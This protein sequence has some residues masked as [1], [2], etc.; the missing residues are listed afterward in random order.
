MITHPPGISNDGGWR[1]FRVNFLLDI[2]ITHV[3]LRVEALI[4]ESAADHMWFGMAAADLVHESLEDQIPREGMIIS[5]RPNAPKPPTVI[6]KTFN[7]LTLGWVAPPAYK[8]EDANEVITAYTLFRRL[9]GADNQPNT[10][11]YKEV[12]KLGNV[13][14]HTV[15][16]L[17]FGTRYQFLL[18]ATNVVGHSNYS[19][20]LLAE[21][22]PT[23]PAAPG[24]PG[25][26]GNASAH[27]MWIQYAKPSHTGAAPLTG[28]KVYK[29][30]VVVGPAGS[31]DSGTMYDTSRTAYFTGLLR[32]Q[33][34]Q[35]QVS[36][37]NAIGEG[38]KS[39]VSGLI[40][41]MLEKEC[42]VSVRI[43]R[44][45]KVNNFPY[46]IGK[47]QAF[48]DMFALDVHHA[49]DILPSRVE[50]T[51]T[52]PSTR[53]LNFQ[54]KTSGASGQKSVAEAKA[55]FI[56]SLVNKESKL[57]SGAVTYMLDTHY[58]FY[59]SIAPDLAA[60]RSSL[61]G[62]T[63]RLDVNVALLAGFLTFMVAPFLVCLQ[64]LIA[65]RLEAAEA[66]VAYKQKY[67]NEVVAG[68]GD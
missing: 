41:T 53:V 48:K 67:R 17:T 28:Y 13:N 3:E 8:E 2:H 12:A 55:D 58:L 54:L 26:Y 30:Q 59:D 66:A 15:T 50:V 63:Q 56:Q 11:E 42:N 43:R 40:E 20:P 29:R 57:H 6:A 61:G 1:E 46:G 64:G 19:E 33:S 45:E 10:L 32:G 4:D 44:D 7:S 18:R 52:N 36:A 14:S 34:Y 25:L 68:G 24:K 51:A 62:P 9:A 49:I 5:R 38:P 22:A 60:A 21:T 39:L 23:V 47:A 35:Y 37:V 31:Y 65:E 16:G 27:T